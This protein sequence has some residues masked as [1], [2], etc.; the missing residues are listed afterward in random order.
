[1]SITLLAIALTT[2]LVYKV[3]NGVFRLHLRWRPLLLCAACALF[4]SMVLPRIVISM[5]GLAGTIGVSALF[6]FLGALFAVRYDEAA[7][8]SIPAAADGAYAADAATSAGCEHEARDGATVKAVTLASSPV[9]PGG[10]DA[11]PRTCAWPEDAALYAGDIAGEPLAAMLVYSVKE[12]AAPL[13]P[14]GTGDELL[15]YA[16]DRLEHG[17]PTA[18]LA[19]FR[20]AL[21]LAPAHEAAPLIVVQI[22]NILKNSGAYDEAIHVFTQGKNLPA[23]KADP[24]LTAEFT[25]TM[26]FL[27]ITKD[28]LRQHHL[29]SLPFG[30]IPTAVYDKIQAELQEWR[31]LG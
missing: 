23:V 30:K 7:A 4:I 29:G 18:A 14:W 1:M 16:F 20:R 13:R 27:R 17:F 31:K 12:E 3:A 11:A 24:L 25:Q 15:D 2:L 5:T 9:A 10:A 28:V 8:A 6:A 19:A 21:R 22:G 26:A